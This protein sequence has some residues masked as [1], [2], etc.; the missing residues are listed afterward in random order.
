MDPANVPRAHGK[1]FSA[2]GFL[3]V[4]IGQL[5]Q[6]DKPAL[7]AIIPLGQAEHEVAPLLELIDP[8]GQLTQADW[9]DEL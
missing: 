6:E 7:G 5:E 1:Q 8:T 4:P 2:L 3:Y 9:P